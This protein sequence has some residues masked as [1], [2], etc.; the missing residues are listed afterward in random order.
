MNKLGQLYE[1]LA[2]DYLQ[3]QGLQL[4]QRNFQCKL[5]EIDLV[6]REGSCLVFVEVKYRASNAFGGAAAAVT[7]SKQQK[8]LRTSRWYLQQHRLTEQT[9]RLDVMAIE[10]QAPYQYQWIKNAFTQ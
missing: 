10:G 7:R 4:V 5:G 6:M 9:C 3:N 1:Q 8:L 2:L